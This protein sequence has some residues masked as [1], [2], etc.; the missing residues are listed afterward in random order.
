MCRVLEVS[1]SGYYEWRRVETSPREAEDA[2]L[3]DL[4]K[5]L[6]TESLESYGVRRI[7]R[8]LVHQ[9]FLV[10]HKRIRRL[11]RSLGLSGKGEPKRFKTTTDSNHDQPVADNLL[12]RRFT[13]DRSNIAW[14]S[15]LTYIWTDEGW[16]YLA[17]IVDLFSRMVVGWA[18]APRITASLVSLALAFGGCKEA[19]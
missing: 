2:R 5:V 8:G 15:D 9:G 13:V 3:L 14:V 1:R 11:M 4:I 16:V 6:H 18:C 19:T 10:N 17:V 7:T 12:K